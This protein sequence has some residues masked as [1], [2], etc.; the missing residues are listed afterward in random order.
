MKANMRSNGRRTV[1]ALTVALGFGLGGCTDLLVEPTS[2]VGGGTLYNDPAAYRSF[3]AKIYAGLALTGQQG[4]S[5]Q[6]DLDPNKIDEGFSQ[7][8]RGLWMLQELPTDMAVLGWLS[9]P[10]VPEMN[11]N[12]WG[13]TNVWP[14]G[15]Y[16]RIFFQIALANEFLRETSADA[17]ASRGHGGIVEIPQYR[18]EARALRA[19]SY[20]HGLDLFGPIPLITESY[21]AGDP[22]P[23][24]VTRLE[25]FEFVESELLAVRSVLPAPTGGSVNYARIDQGVVDMILAKLYLNA[26]AYG[27]GARYADALTAAENVIAGGYTLEPE[28][29]DL[30]LADNHTSDEIIFAVPFDGLRI[31]TW[32]GTTFLTH[33]AVG[34]SMDPADYGIDFPWGGIRVTQ[35]FVGLFEGGA[36][37]PDS[38]ANL[39]YTSGQNL[40]VDN[41]GTFSAGYAYPKFQN[42]TSTGDPGSHSTHTDN[43]LPMFRLADAYLIYAEACFRSGGGACEATA[44]SY[45]NAVRT[46]AYGNTSGNVDFDAMSDQE[47]LDFILDERGRE[48]AWEGHRRTD[49]IRYGLFT[50]GEYVWAFKGGVAAGT[51]VPEFRDLYP[52]PAIELAANPNIDQNPGY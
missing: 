15:M 12:T 47:V 21:A 19:L 20:W 42:V 31:Q 46:R 9:D 30:F 27:A 7:Y 14:T 41:L 5:G 52:I 8:A 33:A 34:G 48:L 39:L 24:Q 3:L 6:P 28:F 36:S 37:G 16:Y 43:D 18:A 51:S 25:I 2:T 45:V 13:S 10:G 23:A 26:E 49:L 50:G 1:L 32:G 11:Q 40:V 4:P 22:P 17:L 35:Q 44:E 29:G 38:R